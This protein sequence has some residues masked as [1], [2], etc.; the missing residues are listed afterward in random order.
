MN[1][2]ENGFAKSLWV[3][4]AEPAVDA[5]ALTGGI[6]A[7]V[8]VVGAGYTGLSAALHLAEMG[9]SVAV[10]EAREIAWGGSGRNGAHVNPGWKVLP[11]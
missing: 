6:D 9:Q 1:S 7:D 5:P 2:A 4:T 10:L 11:S 3:T 8:V